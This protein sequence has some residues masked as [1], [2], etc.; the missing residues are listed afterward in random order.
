MINTQQ[1]F[2]ST[3]KLTAVI[4]INISTF[5]LYSVSVSAVLF[6]SHTQGTALQIDCCVQMPQFVPV[7][8]DETP[9]SERYKKQNKMP[10]VDRGSVTDSLICSPSTSN[11][12]ILRNLLV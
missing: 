2:F 3:H 6:I 4:D 9:S 12:D 7:K 11:A 5:L 8:D 1:E 10:T